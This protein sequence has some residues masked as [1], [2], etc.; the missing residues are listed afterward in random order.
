[1]GRGRAPGEAGR[2]RGLGGGRG[3]GSA[4]TP[5]REGE[6]R[7]RSAC[8][9]PTALPG[10]G[11][12]KVPHRVGYG[13]FFRTNPPPL[14]SCGGASLPAGS[15]PSGRRSPASPPPPLGSVGG[16]GEACFLD[17]GGSSASGKGRKLL[18]RFLVGCGVVRGTPGRE[19]R[20]ELS[21]SKPGVRGKQG[22]PTP[23]C[24]PE[25]WSSNFPGDPGADGPAR[26]S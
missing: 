6:G 22:W 10:V 25:R 2:L 4:R 15:S 21:Q 5:H 17:S 11:W 24:S 16:S 9:N 8:G 3:V 20:L 19:W 12:G 14:N 1:M 23:R 13:A 18:P 26:P 7:G